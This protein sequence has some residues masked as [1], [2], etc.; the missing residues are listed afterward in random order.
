MRASEEAPRDRPMEVAIGNLLRAGVVLAAA[1]GLIGGVAYFSS[2]GA[3]PTDFH[4]FH[5][6]DPRLRSIHRVVDAALARDSAAIMQLG[7]LLLVATPIV[8]VALSL[9]A[10]ARHRDAMY[11]AVSAVVLSLLLFSLLTGIG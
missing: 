6:V 7:L 3:Q 1:V 5:G 4:A 9:V 11:V 2:H 10:F 8:R